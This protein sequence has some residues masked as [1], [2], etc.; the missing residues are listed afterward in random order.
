MSFRTDWLLVDPVEL[1]QES[2]LPTALELEKLATED[3]LTDV[4]K[5][6]RFLKAGQISQKL[7]LVEYLPQM[8][9]E[10]ASDR[11]L[12]ELIVTAT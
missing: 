7:W 10:P 4:Q 12:A 6:L 11:L 9:S 5:G 3:G 2:E 8:I 1:V